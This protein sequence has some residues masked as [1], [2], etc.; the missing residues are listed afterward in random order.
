MR[1]RAVFQSW[2]SCVSVFLV[3]AMT[4]AADT[5]PQP[6]K[7][8]QGSLAAA[9]QHAKA[10]FHPITQADV[11]QAKTVLMDAL[12]R[13]DNKLTEAGVH[14]EGWRKY[15]HW[16][17]LQKSVGGD[18]KQDMAR[19][20][21]IY[22][23]FTRGYDGLELAWFLDVQHALEN[24]IVTANAVGSGQVRTAYEEILDKL[25]PTLDAYAAKPTTRDALVIS[26]SVRWLQ[27]AHQASALVG[28]IQE[29]FVH[30]NVIGYAS[31]GLVGAGVVD[32]VDD[33]TQINDC[34]LGTSITG[35]AHTLGRTSAALA[36]NSD[37]GV[38]DTL[39]FGKTHSENVGYHRPVTIFSTAETGL[40][41]VKRV[42]ITQSGL[43]S[44][45]AASNAETHICI[46]DIQSRKGRGLVQRMA[47]K[48]AGKQQSEAECIASSHAEQRLNERIDEQAA[49]PLDKANQQYTEKYK[50]P[51]SDRNLFP[52]LLHFSTTERALGIL[53]LQAG[54]GKV[55]APGAPPPVIEGAD[56]TLQ[57]HES[58]IN[59]LAFD[60]LAGRTIYEEKVQATA[61]KVLGKLPDKLK[62][63]K[64]GKPWTITFAAREPVTVTFADDG[65]K[66]TING[67]KFYKG[68]EYCDATTV[69]ASYKIAKTPEGFKA[70]RQGIV[71]VAPAG[72][73]PDTGGRQTAIR[74][75]LQGRFDKILEP[76]FVEK[77][78][79]LSGRW[80]AAGKL[81]PIQVKS[82]NGWL[83]I[84]WNRV[85]AGPKA[86]TAKARATK[87]AV[88]KVAAAK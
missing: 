57:L 79:E 76:E 37:M 10:D 48:R 25:A 36:P 85:A 16:E 70:I 28:T 62:G 22:G 83:V 18:T 34:I 49:E 3:A 20:T 69:W 50:Q 88:A 54:G 29:R 33:V 84:A 14:G 65:F 68:D 7:A 42:W 51:F 13:L 8:P 77:G 27:N 80:K 15:L 55:A 11:A 43:S 56:M 53:G 44:F 47:W 17:L 19:L 30:P 86:A 73:S 46:Q 45:P 63:D 39:F 61:K 58:A 52:Q 71:N 12:G 87:A 1:P 75:V 59:N 64:D 26:E 41:G 4:C 23:L 6:T 9:C 35:T 24:Y 72:D 2:I 5:T 21:K 32:S 40:A 74:S 82:R 60:A 31:A 78:I 67:V 38:I 81:M 66:I